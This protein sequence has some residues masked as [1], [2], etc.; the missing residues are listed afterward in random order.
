MKAIGQY[1]NKMYNYYDINQQKSDDLRVLKSTA[2]LTPVPSTAFAT[3]N[4]LNNTVETYLPDDYLHMLGCIVEFTA[5]KPKYKCYLA[6]DKVQYNAHRLTA[7]M[8]PG[9]LNNHY[10]KPSYKN[11]YFYINNVTTSSTFPTTDTQIPIANIVYNQ[12]DERYGNKN[13]VKLE[14]RYGSDASIFVPSS[15]YVD[16]LRAPQL[17]RLTQ[18]QIDEVT[19]T[20]QILEFPDYVCQEIVNEL[21]KLLLENASDPRLQT[22]IPINQTIGIQQ[23][24]R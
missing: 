7:D 1:I 17:L 13:R 20:S 22:N 8:F 16:Y 10:F 4:L 18:D 21:V 2:I 9:I 12:E 14:I 5:V 3:N 23:Q 6:G 11:P 24:Q 15:I 19:D